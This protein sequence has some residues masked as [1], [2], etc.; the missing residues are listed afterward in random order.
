MFEIGSRVKI[1]KDI[2]MHNDWKA[3][4]NEYG[5]VESIKTVGSYDV[6]IRWDDG[7]GS[8]V[9]H[10]NCQE[11]NKNIIDIEVGDTIFTVQII[12]RRSKDG[13]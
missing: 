3:H 6:V 1:V 10:E 13:K 11:E 5:T 12:G 9:P 2:N 7:K 4:E 8:H